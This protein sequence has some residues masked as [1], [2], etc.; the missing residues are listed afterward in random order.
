MNPT[1]GLLES[2][3]L[4]LPKVDAR[5]LLVITSQDLPLDG[6]LQPILVTVGENHPQPSA[7]HLSFLPRR[8]EERIL[9]AVSLALTRGLVS[10]GD[11]LVCLVEGENGFLDSL[12]LYRVRGGE[13]LLAR[14][15]SEP[16]LKA[17]VDLCRELAHPAGGT[18]IG[19][20]FVVGDEERVLERSRQLMPNP[21]EGHDI[22]I[23]NRHYWD[24]VKRYAKAFDGAFVVGE[25]GRVLAAMRY[26]VAEGEVRLP[27]GLGTRHRAVAGITSL[28]RAV[29]VTVSGEDGM[30]RV[31]ERG[32]VMAVIHPLNGTLELLKQEV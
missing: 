7:L 1:A 14:L 15:E 4:L 6:D 10:E 12:F 3:R 31:F 21:F 20:A 8:R 17:T 18:P 16:V 25:D 28:T 5:S 9:H 26:L 13:P 29:G 30:V 24:L 11:L 2:A 23:T 22:R 32:E 19:A 27:Q